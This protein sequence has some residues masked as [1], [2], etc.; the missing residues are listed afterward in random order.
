MVTRPC[1]VLLI[2]L[3]TLFFATA[4]PA[5]PITYKVTEI[6]TF[7]GNSS[8]AFGI[9]ERGDVTGTSVTKRGYDHA[10]LYRNGKLVDLTPA[11][12]LNTVGQ[13][14]N[15]RD[16]I[17]LYSET[18]NN[19]YAYLWSRGRLQRLLVPYLPDYVGE[20]GTR[21]AVDRLCDWQI[22]GLSDRGTV[23]GM[24]DINSDEYGY[25]W[26]R[27]RCHLFPNTSPLF[28]TAMNNRGDY[29]FN[30]YALNSGESRIGYRLHG[31]ATN[32]RLPFSAIMDSIICMS[33]M[34][35]MVGVRLSGAQVIMSAYYLHNGKSSRITAA[36][37]TLVRPSAIDNRG[38]VVG[39]CRTGQG[40]F[41]A[42][43]Y[44]A[45]KVYDLN[46][47]IGPKSGWVLKDARGINN[48]GQIVGYGTF[49]GHMRGFILTPIAGVRL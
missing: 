49:H 19:N 15:D 13:F 26:R 12:R 21:A 46:T 2:A 37:L 27:S 48:K 7:G 18:R 10:F 24:V 8:K 28:P 29:A 9:N 20:L 35:E 38:E 41:Q 1:I 4:A 40:V 5:H 22:A 6:G 14:V 23:A 31:S 16:Q 44:F 42:F 34:R 11:M 30:E 43:L 33:D 32:V 36:G 25:L 39:G 3:S 45:G 17:A 47:L